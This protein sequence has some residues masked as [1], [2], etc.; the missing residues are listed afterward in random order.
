VDKS[1]VVRVEIM[2]ADN[3]AGGWRCVVDDLNQKG[4]NKKKGGE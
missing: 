4:A 2:R 1:R 3:E